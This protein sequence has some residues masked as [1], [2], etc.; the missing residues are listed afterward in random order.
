MKAATNN[1]LAITG[2]TVAFFGLAVAFYLNLWGRQRGLAPIPATPPD[3]TN[4]A[5]V[6]ISAAELFRTG[7]D[8]SGMACYSCHD[9]KKLVV[10]QLDTNGAIKLP[11][12]HRDLVLKHGRNNRNDHCFNCHDPKNLEQ[13]RAR[14]GQ[15]FKL[16]ESTLLCASCHGPTYRD[17]SVGIHGRT[18]GFWDRTRGDIVRQDCTACHDPH[19]PAFPPMKPG[20]GPHLL[21]PKTSE[22]VS[23]KEGNR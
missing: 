18:S 14:E 16:T 23:T 2:L 15:A 1:P 11:E 7:G 8:T 22:P 20:P 10:V 3:F 13:L 21:H 12:E 9:Q 19:A 6:R 4:T 17:W 5:T